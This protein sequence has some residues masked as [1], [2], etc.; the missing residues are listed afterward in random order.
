[1]EENKRTINS[2]KNFMFPPF[3]LEI[4]FLCRAAFTDR[5]LLAIQKSPLLFPGTGA[6][7]NLLKPTTGALPLPS[8]YPLHKFIELITKIN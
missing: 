7:W 6:A 2:S 3:N 4:T 5:A 1:M 8:F